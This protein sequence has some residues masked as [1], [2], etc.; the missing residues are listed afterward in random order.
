LAQ[1]QANVEATQA[2]TEATRQRT[3]AGRLGTLYGLQDRIKQIRDLIAAGE[4]K[5]ED[6]DAMVAAEQRGTTVYDAMKQQASDQLTARGQTAG[7]LG[8]LAGDFTS[9]FNTGFSTIADMNKTAA[10]GSSAG[11]DAFLSLLNIAQDRLGQYKLPDV[12]TPNYLGTG[13]AAGGLANAA[14]SRIGAPAPASPA[15]APM[16]PSTYGTGITGPSTSP[17]A[18]GSGGGGQYGG[19]TINIGGGATTPTT[20]PPFAQSGMSEGRGVAPLVGAAA[21]A[22]PATAQDVIAAYPDAARRHGLLM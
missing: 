12:Q 17:S 13:S 20:P 18:G 19:V 21:Q 9:A 15:P 8:S 3:E 22:T 2:G 4:I 6:G 1:G 11:A 14:A 7:N 5:P 16:T 10:I